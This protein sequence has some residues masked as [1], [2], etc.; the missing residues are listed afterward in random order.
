MHIALQTIR[1]AGL[2]CSLFLVSQ[3]SAIT[4]A[5]D[6]AFANGHPITEP[7][8]EMGG[9]ATT[10]LVQRDGK[11]VMG[12]LY[13]YGYGGHFGGIPL[14]RGA[15][16]RYL[17]DGTLDTTFGAGGVVDPASS[18]P[19][20]LLRNGQ[21]IAPTAH[22][23]AR[24]NTDYSPDIS[25]STNGAESIAWYGG[26]GQLLEQRDG[27]VL[28]ASSVGGGTAAL[29]LARFDLDGTLDPSFNYVGALIAPRGP[30]TNDYFGGA[31]LQPD[32]KIV[33]AATS[34]VG[35][36]LMASI[37]RFLPDGSPDASFG[38]NGRALIPNAPNVGYVNVYALVMQPGG[39]F[40]VTS[41]YREDLPNDVHNVSLMIT[42]VTASG[43]LDTTFGTG[44]RFVY[45]PPVDG[46]VGTPRMIVQ[47][48]GKLLTLFVPNSGP[49]AQRPVFLRLTADGDPDASFGANGVWSP[50]DLLD[51]R[52]MALD[53]NGQLVL[54]GGARVGN[55]FGDFATAR[56][57]IGASPIVEY[58]NAALDHY[59]LTPNPME[60]ADLDGGVHSGWS[61]TGNTFPAFGAASAAPDGF[62]PVCRFYIPPAHGDSHFFTASASECA[63]VQSKVQTDPNYS[64]YVF[65]SPNAFY[66]ALP[67]T[68]TGV[69]PDATVP[70][71][72]LWNQ[73][74]DSNH[75]Y[76]TD[77]ALKAQMIAKGY[78]G[79][80][81]GP[82][83]VAMCAGR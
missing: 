33:V 47:P 30:S 50:S 83:G 67:D 45:G 12:G 60:A 56:Y 75:R 70:V 73:R 80:G 65:E 2:L 69:C 24:F 15:V 18:L 58:Y 41:V 11:I 8:L 64:D 29:T 63:E 14:G 37:L 77:P 68:A 7:F 28:V 25:M 62:V 20:L 71:Y 4:P 26:T 76:V 66:A 5:L 13:V 78:L 74:A 1:A 39:R 31:V 55:R 81:Y 49:L 34:T 51:V 82:D 61:R 6:P 36:V 27:K 43:A 52:G 53:A 10:P 19:Q 54:A 44:G 79:E 57:T 35:G 40:V 17:P 22:G 48:D 72:R 9:V 42:R 16:V 21:F 38:S 3:A 32:G 59:F 46:L 23:I